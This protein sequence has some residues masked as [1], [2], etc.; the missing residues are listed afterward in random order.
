MPAYLTPDVYRLSRQTEKRDIR[1]VRT[2]V[3]GFVG[4][5]ERGPL[6]APNATHTEA[7]KAAVRLTSWDAFLATFGGFTLYG[8]LPYAVRAF[9]DNGGTACYVVRIAALESTSGLQGPRKASFLLPGTQ[10]TSAN[11]PDAAILVAEA[12]AGNSELVITDANLNTGQKI[13]SGD[14]LEINSGGV[15]EFLMVVRRE[16]DTIRLAKRLVFKHSPGTSLSKY[17]PGLVV[18]ATSE[19]SW[20]NLIELTVTALTA[21]NGIEEFALRVSLMPGLDR[22]RP[23]EEEYFSRLSFAKGP[24]NALDHV[25]GFSRLIRLTFDESTGSLPSL[26]IS[27][28][29]LKAGTVKLQGGQDGLGNG[30]T[31]RDMTGGPDDLRGLRIL[32][33]VDDIAI[34]CAPDAVFEPPLALPKPNPPPT[35]PCAPLSATTE[36]EQTGDEDATAIPPALDDPVNIY[37]AMIDQCERLRYRVAILDFPNDKKNPR[38]LQAWK[39]QFTTRFAAIYYPWVRVPDPLG[40]EGSSRRVP[41][42][43]HVAGVYARID[44]Q[45]G[46]DRPPANAALEFVTDLANDVT[47]LDQQNLNP[48][49]INAIRSFRGRRIRVWGARSL[50]A[51]DDSDWRFIHVRRLMSMIEKSVELSLRWTVFELNNFALRRTLVHSLSVFLE[52]IWRKGGLKGALPDQAFYV[53]CDD[54]NNP[55]VVVDSGQVICEIGV[56]VA[57]PMEFLVFEIRQDP[58]AAQL[59]ET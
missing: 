58:A 1:L 29:P 4:F 39:K 19:G 35:D 33:E 43:G 54:T 31:V 40:I 15:K 20:G 41:V 48:W 10:L 49:G 13:V 56:A 59:T 24:F 8:Y 42:A 6:A 36:K 53:K 23:K 5:A 16:N 7:L 11:A 9:F 51:D 26:L 55:P 44:N 52:A 2:D 27:D 22:S 45:F 46:V 57:V 25:N 30:V 12:Q 34:L 17:G 18:T 28:G 37:R 38:E 50:A 47:D 3:A 14:L 21:D 32:E